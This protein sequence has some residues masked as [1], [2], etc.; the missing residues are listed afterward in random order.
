MHTHILQDHSWLGY[1]IMQ[2]LVRLPP[3][4]NTVSSP[5]P[6]DILGPIFDYFADLHTGITLSIQRSPSATAITIRHSNEA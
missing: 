2:F 5:A 6:Q 3:S 4:Y 1:Q